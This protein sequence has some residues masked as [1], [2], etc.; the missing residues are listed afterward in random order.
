MTRDYSDWSLLPLQPANPATMWCK[1]QRTGA[2]LETFYSLDGQTYVQMRQALLTT[3][4]EVG[5]V[6]PAPTGPGFV[7]TFEEFTIRPSR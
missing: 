1:V 3:T 4:L 5:M 2:C 6:A 7:V